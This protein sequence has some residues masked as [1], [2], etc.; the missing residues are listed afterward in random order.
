MG[1][2]R[3]FDLDEALD[4][5]LDVFWRHGYEGATIPHLTK[6]MGI[7]RP[8]LYAAFG[9]KEQL[10][11]NVIHRY[12]AGPVAYA[13]EALK[14]PTA[15]A[16][17]ERLFA[18]F[19]C[20]LTNRKNPRGCLLVHGALASGDESASIRQEL[21]AIREELVNAIRDRFKQ[22]VK[23][24]DLPTGTDYAALARY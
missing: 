6:A 24:G 14:E 20:G 15:R 8:S 18:G 5:A 13:A 10:F 23:D 22:A 1:R 3:E 11:R 21:A 7:N 9:S 4:R 12:R 2:P 19:M 16:V 17:T